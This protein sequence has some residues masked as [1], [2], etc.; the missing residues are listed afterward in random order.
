MS[1][2]IATVVGKIVCEL[3][4][5]TSEERQR[6]IAGALAVLGE[7][8]PAVSAAVGNGFGRAN[9]PGARHDV[10]GEFSPRGN[11]W[12]EKSGLSSAQLE[13]VFQFENGKVGLILGEA[14]GKGKREQTINTYILTGAA[15][16]L[17]SGASDFTDEAAR[18]NC[19]NVGCYDAANHAKT[20]KGFGNRLTGS[21]SAGWRLTSPGLTAAAALIKSV[22]SGSE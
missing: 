4:D 12:V 18:T 6:A 20:S 14:I 7:S 2:K 13:E 1:K 15:A 16:L 3:E 8:A 17:E 10:S 19:I 9:T 5:L 22:K 21:K 11:A